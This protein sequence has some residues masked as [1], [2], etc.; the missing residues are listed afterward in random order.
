MSSGGGTSENFRF[1]KSVCRQLTELKLTN[2][3][4][5]MFT[6]GGAVAITVANSIS[7]S[8]LKMISEKV[9]ESFTKIFRKKGTPVP[10]L[11]DPGSLAAQNERSAASALWFAV[12]SER[13]VM[14]AEKAQAAAHQAQE[15]YEQA[16]AFADQAQASAKEARDGS[17]S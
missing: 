13:T 3:A 9:S 10:V 2:V 11:A 17:S 8:A 16:R 6:V 14:E 7:D 4:G 5:I 1:L 12:L 15:A